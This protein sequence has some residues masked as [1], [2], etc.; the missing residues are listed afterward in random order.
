MK[1]T[2]SNLIIFYI[3]SH[4]FECR[5]QPNSFTDLFWA[6]KVIAYPRLEN[7][8]CI[9]TSILCYIAHQHTYCISLLARVCD[10]FIHNTHTYIYIAIHAHI[11]THYYVHLHTYTYMHTCMS[12]G[13]PSVCLCTITYYERLGLTSNFSAIFAVMAAIGS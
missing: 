10:A 4:K 6:I 7:T 8:V 5:C 1:N 11:H 9:S 3:S 2:I 13:Y 12:K